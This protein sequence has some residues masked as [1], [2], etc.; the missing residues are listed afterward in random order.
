[1]VQQVASVGDRGIVHE[2][3]GIREGAIVSE[4]GSAV[5]VEHEDVVE[6]GAGGVVDRAE[7]FER[8]VIIECATHFVEECG[9][10]VVVHVAVVV[11]HAADMVL[12]E[13]APKIRQCAAGFVGHRAGVLNQGTG[14]AYWV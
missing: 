1:M 10:K 9:V 3:G 5:I 4:R 12:N 11:K 14:I 7:I 6:H 2:Q 13:A 8:V